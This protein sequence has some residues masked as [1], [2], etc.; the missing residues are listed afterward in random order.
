M[1]AKCNKSQMKYL[2]MQS[3]AAAS[4]RYAAGVG[5]A[6]F[7]MPAV[8]SGGGSSR[9]FLFY[10]SLICFFFP[11]FFDASVVCREDPFLCQIFLFPSFDLE[12]STAQQNT[13]AA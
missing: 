2:L 6:C 8:T 13:R 5:G 7:G 4:G 1:L 9:R 10:L 12:D 11:S 3:A